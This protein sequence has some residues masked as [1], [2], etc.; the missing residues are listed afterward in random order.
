MRRV[1]NTRGEFAL[2]ERF[3]KKLQ[4][5]FAI[6]DMQVKNAG[7]AR[8]HTAN[9]RVARESQNFIKCRLARTVIAD[10]DFADTNNRIDEYDV[11]ANA[12]GQRRWGDV[13]T[14]R[15]TPGTHAFLAQG[16]CLRHYRARVASRVVGPQQ[17]NN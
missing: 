16:I 17:A 13:L 5:T 14:T 11:V 9:M 7:F 1:E 4:S 2:L 10:G 3:A 6:T 8:D 15:M 12:A